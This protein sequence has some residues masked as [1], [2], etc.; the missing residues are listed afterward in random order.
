MILSENRPPL[1][2]IMLAEL[3]I[4]T[5]E[6]AVK[7]AENAWESACVG[8]DGANRSDYVQGS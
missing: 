4:K 1:F 5:A 6:L 3:Q 8:F 2:G 7:Y